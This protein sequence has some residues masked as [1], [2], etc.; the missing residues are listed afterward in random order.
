MWSLGCRFVA[1]GSEGPCIV[2]AASLGRRHPSC[3]ECWS[4]AYLI[5]KRLSLDNLFL[6]LLV[7]GRLGIPRRRQRTALTWGI[8]G[9]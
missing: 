3:S 9:A 5:E 6:F 1:A 4:T 7:V 8:F 2:R